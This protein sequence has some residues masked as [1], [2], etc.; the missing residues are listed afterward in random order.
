MPRPRRPRG[1]PW[2]LRSG[3]GEL[4]IAR[5]LQ[6]EGAAR[7]A[8]QL[9]PRREPGRPP[10]SSRPGEQP[11]RALGASG[12]LTSAAR[13]FCFSPLCP[14]DDGGQ[15]RKKGTWALACS[16]L[17]LRTA[18][19]ASSRHSLLRARWG[20]PDSPRRADSQG[21][22]NPVRPSVF[23]AHGLGFRVCSVFLHY[24]KIFF[25]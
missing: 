21:A 13:R 20:E 8:C 7:D 10:A 17:L 16:A 19:E 15:A 22:R 24:L 6:L 4:Q 25:S 14:R 1:G 23:W 12:Q 2:I 9:L 3:C 5:Q 11:R 18:A